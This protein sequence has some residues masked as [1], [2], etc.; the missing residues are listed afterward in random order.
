[1]ASRAE[2]PLID[3]GIKT[4]P[5]GEIGAKFVESVRNQNLF[6]YQAFARHNGYS[7]NDALVEMGLMADAAVRASAGEITAVCPLFPYARQDRKASGREPISA[8]WATRLLAMS[9]VGR[10]VTVDLHSAQTQ[11]VFNG[12]FDHLTA[13]P[14][15]TDAIA[16]RI[17]GEQ[18][19]SV[20]I[21]PDAGRAKVAEELAQDLD[22][23]MIVMPKS[24]GRQDSSQIS[25]SGTVGD[26]RN[27]IC[28]I[29]D[30]MIDTGG[31]IASAAESLREAGARSVIVCATHGLFNGAAGRKLNKAP[32]DGIIVTNTVP[33]K[34]SQEMFG[35]KLQ[36]LDVAPMLA[37][38]IG[39]IARGE[40][41]S[42]MFGGKNYQ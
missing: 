7:V 5:S 8:A 2:L 42:K 37:E 1:M 20:V 15:I 34:A 16:G 30:D 22:V 11:A 24:R 38:A 28:Y 18:H 12:P 3:A 36:V 32:I 39:R 41:L 27:M 33:Q 6:L 14:M 17:D 13:M 9:G 29:N 23:E 4:F 35:D 10:I 26:V 19:R 40:S 31:T 25:R 21:S